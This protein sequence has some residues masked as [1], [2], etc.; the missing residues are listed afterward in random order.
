MVRCMLRRISPVDCAAGG[1]ARPVQPRRSPPRRH[2]WAA[3]SAPRR[4][5]RSR[6]PRCAAARPNTTR[7]ISELPP[8]RLAPCTE[9]QPASPTAIR[10]ATTRV[11]VAVRAGHHLGQVVGR[12][13]AHVVVAG[14]HHRDRLPGDVDAGEDLRGLRDAGQALV[15]QI[16]VEM[17]EMQLDVVPVRPAAAPLVDLDRHGAADH[18]ARGEVLGGRARSAP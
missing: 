13:A 6:P 9:V 1:V 14:R 15:Q 18:V 4:A 11:G 7:S 2:P 16:R 5:S 3:A 17:L 8:S 10:P 12:D